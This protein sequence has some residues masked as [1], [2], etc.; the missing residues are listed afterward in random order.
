MANQT[1]TRLVIVQVNEQGD[2][3]REEAINV[4][5]HQVSLP[6]NVTLSLAHIPAG[7]FQ[8]GAGNHFV[9]PDEQPVHHVHVNAS[10]LG[11]FTITQRQWQAVM[12]TLPPCRGQGLDH[13]VDRVSRF[14]ARTFCN[15]LADLTQMPFRLPSEAEWEYAC[16]A[17]STTDFA[18]GNM[19]TTDL[20]NYVGWHAYLN[21]PKG[22]YRHGPMQVGQFPPNRWG[23]YDMH[24]N[25]WEWCEDAWHDNYL[26][27]PADGTAWLRDGSAGKVV[28]GG[29]WHDPPALCRSS[30][31]LKLMPQEGEDFVGVRV[32]LPAISVDQSF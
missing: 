14:E 24:G 6:G 27:A 5:L 17:G 2:W 4:S 20:A 15:R 16:R 21:G 32:A 12:K 1:T 18:I 25:V 30:A 9:E 31:R 13:P 29:S 3:I 19:I 23:L 22:E 28:R 7:S 8:M 10:L 11:Q 26:N